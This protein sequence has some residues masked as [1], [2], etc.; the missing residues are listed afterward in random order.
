MSTAHNPYQIKAFTHVARERSFSKAAQRL[1]VT[2]S[3]ATQHV[4]KLERVM[5]TK[6]FI[7]R[8]DGL[9]LTRA[10]HQLFKIT[11]RLTS[12][13]QLVAEKINDYSA[14]NDGYIRIIA[15]A[16]RPAM[17]II[18][19]FG[20]LYPQVQIDFKTFDWTTA[21]SLLQERQIDVAI[22]TEPSQTDSLFTR[23]IRRSRY[24]AHMRK[25]HRLAGRHSISLSEL[26]SETLVLPEDGSLTQ[27]LAKAKIRDHRLE[28]PRVLKT[29]T[30]P[31]VKEALLHDLGVGLL[32]EN[33]LYPSQDLVAVPIK[34][35]AEEYRDFV[36]IP[37]DKEDLRITKS[38][39]GVCIEA[40]VS[41]IGIQGRKAAI[42]S[43]G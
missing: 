10:G 29:T 9:E 18:A 39:L 43:V 2:Q 11:D 19:R 12:L 41:E 32:L 40:V 30:F 28:F 7:R 13:D 34:E 16:P 33:S 21:M 23:E 14:L 37:K 25:D 24:M 1:G 27:K 36:V 6:L 17:P 5:G 31:M 4:A 8:R 22:V 3:S 15:T 26:Q 20:V 38:F 42:E 35:M